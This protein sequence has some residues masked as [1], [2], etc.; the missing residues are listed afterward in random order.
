MGFLSGL[1]NFSTSLFNKS[2]EKHQIN[3][4]ILGGI[5]FF[6]GLGGV[7]TWGNLNIYIFS[8]FKNKANLSSPNQN[9][10]ILPIIAIPLAIISIFSIQIAERVGF[11]KVILSSAIIYSAS[12]I[13]SSF[14]ENLYIFTLFYNFIPALALGFSMNPV[15]YSVWECYPEIK[16]KI[17]GYMFGVFQLSTLFYNLIGTIIVNPNNISA[18]EKSLDGKGTEL[19]YYNEEVGNNVPKMV[20]T[21]GV[22]YF[23]LTV[24]GGYLIRPVIKPKKTEETIIKELTPFQI[25]M[26]TSKNTNYEVFIEEK[27]KNSTKPIEGITECPSVKSGILTRTF[28][29]LFINSGLVAALALYFNINF[30]TFSLTRLNNDYYVTYLY[31]FNAI[32]GGIGRVFWGHIIDIY[33]FKSVFIFLEI[34]VFVNGIIFPF[35]TNAIFYC[36]MVGLVAFFDGG[37]ISIIGPGLL[38]IYGMNT[39]AKL[40]PVKG[41]SFFLGL[42]ICP[43]VGFLLEKSLGMSN[44]LLI[45]GAINIIG[46][47]LSFFIKMKYNWY[48]EPKDK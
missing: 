31:I 29:I 10:L 7:A 43:I 27:S 41:L 3:R 38:N 24:L 8:F 42:I 1:K 13:L 33:S 37:L 11:K 22:I 40:L 34:M 28:L 6:S 46:I 35:A 20:L 4:S 44:V 17:S 18:T 26:N 15:I 9:N 25:E 23:M 36:F 47:L 14:F 39:G 48:V 2:H 30:K 12:I 5:L 16:G 21:L 45:L 19:N 32:A